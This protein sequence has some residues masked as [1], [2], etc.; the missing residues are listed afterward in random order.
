MQQPDDEI[1]VDGSASNAFYALRS[2]KRLASNSRAEEGAGLWL[3]VMLHTAAASLLVAWLEQRDSNAPYT[4]RSLSAARGVDEFGNHRIEPDRL[5]LHP[6]DTLQDKIQSSEQE[7]AGPLPFGAVA[8]EV[9]SHISYVRNWIQH[10]KPVS[11]G[12]P[13]D[14][15]RDLLSF[16]IAYID[17]VLRNLP[18][19]P[20]TATYADVSFRAEFD[21]VR[22][23]LRLGG[24]LAVPDE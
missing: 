1:L 24:W 22:D 5:F 6:I 23:A 4:T 9:M 15:I 19:A 8:K 10:P 11:R 21:S 3:L 14:Y 12:V 7:F 16:L 18:V 13:H 2:A 20:Y 17:A